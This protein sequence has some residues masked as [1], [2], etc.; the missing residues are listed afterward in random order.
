MK[1]RPKNKKLFSNFWITFLHLVRLT[2]KDEAS[3]QVDIFVRFLGQVDLGQTYPQ[4]E[5]LGQVDIWSDFS[6]CW[7]L[8]RCTPT[9]D[10]SWPSVILLWVM[11]TFCQMYPLG[12]GFRS[13]WPLVRCTPQ[14]H[15]L[16]KCDTTLGQADLWSDV[17]PTRDISWSI[18]ILL[19]GSGWPLVRCTPQDEALV[20]LTFG[21]TSALADLLSD[22][23][24]QETSCGQVWYYFGSGWPL[25]HMYP[26]DEALG[27]VDIW[28]DVCSCWPLVR[29]TQPETS[30]G[31]V[32][33]YFGSGWPLVRCTCLAQKS[34]GQVWYYFRSGWHLVTC[35]HQMRLQVRLKF[36]KTLFHS[37]SDLLLYK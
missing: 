10:I 17:P 1:W 20:R 12:W 33:Y 3:D 5:A 16:P 2:P 18:V 25:C 23:P 7:P 9:R 32:W 26:Q 15:L 29:C 36:G 8:V 14:R 34:C 27:Q 37:I 22:V 35:T 24:P 13:G 30:C 11:L 4:D 31:Q 21:Q 6:S 19:W 28:L